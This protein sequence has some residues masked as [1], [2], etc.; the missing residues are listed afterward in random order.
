MDE[1]E[2]RYQE[3]IQT[4]PAPINLFDATGEIVWGNDAV[5]DLLALDSRDD[6]IGRSIFEFIRPADRFTAE[7]ELAEVVDE[8]RSAGPTQ[9]QLRTDEG[10]ERTIRVATAPG[11]YKGK[12]SARLSSSTSRNSIR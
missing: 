7:T 3:L 10:E 8:K 6:L 1:S 2:R 11:R 5:L 9:M 4:S 12:T